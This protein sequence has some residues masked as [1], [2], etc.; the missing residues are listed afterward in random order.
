[1]STFTDNFLEYCL[2]VSIKFCA[3]MGMKHPSDTSEDEPP[4]KKVRTEESLMPESQF[5]AKN[6]VIIESVLIYI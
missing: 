6:K 1:M 3:Q 4:T 2:F 5:L